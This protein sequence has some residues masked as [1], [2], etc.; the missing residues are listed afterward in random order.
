MLRMLK[1]LGYTSVICTVN[2]QEA[3]ILYLAIPFI[4]LDLHMHVIIKQFP[5]YKITPIIAVTAD[6]TG[7]P[8]DLY[9]SQRF[10]DESPQTS[11]TQSTRNSDCRLVQIRN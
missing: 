6:I 11:H 8:L 7:V 3:V 1:K 2:G 4:H 9:R 10:D 5:E